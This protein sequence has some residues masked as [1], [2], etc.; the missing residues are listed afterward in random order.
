[1]KTEKNAKLRAGYVVMRGFICRRHLPAKRICLQIA[2]AQGVEEILSDV[3]GEDDV[4]II[5]DIY[6]VRS[7]SFQ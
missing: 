4:K 2:P 6:T 7:I 5:G 3:Y 1:M